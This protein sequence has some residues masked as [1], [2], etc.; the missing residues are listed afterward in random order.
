MHL[1]WRFGD[2]LGLDIQRST[3]VLG[4]LDLGMTFEL[5]ML[6]A[7]Y[8]GVGKVLDDRNALFFAALDIL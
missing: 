1:Y 5:L 4:L 8:G 6:R 7:F 3:G 2:R